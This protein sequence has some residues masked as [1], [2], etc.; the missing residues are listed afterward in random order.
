MVRQQRFVVPLRRKRPGRVYFSL[1]PSALAFALALPLLVGY[2]VGQR[3]DEPE[4][5]AALSAVPAKQ[6]LALA[7]PDDIEMLPAIAEQDL[8]PIDTHA[9]R[10]RIRSMGLDP[11][12]V[13]MFAQMERDQKAALK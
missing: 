11:K 1:K 12:E 7:L 9:F 13:E 5:S 10:Q 8:P 3:T 4:S 6:E 2:A